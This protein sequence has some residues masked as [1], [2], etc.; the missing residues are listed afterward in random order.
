MVS[1]TILQYVGY[2]K[3]WYYL[4]IHH[5]DI[6]AGASTIMLPYTCQCKTYTRSWCIIYCF[7]LYLKIKKYIKEIPI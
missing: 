5:N 4:F 2:L 3:G 7:D 1:L 6:A